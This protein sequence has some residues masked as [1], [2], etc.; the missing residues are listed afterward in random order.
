MFGTRVFTV[1]WHRPQA[2][3]WHSPQQLFFSI[4]TC[5]ILSRWYGYTSLIPSDTQAGI[6]RNGHAQSIACSS[7]LLG[8]TSHSMSSVSAPSQCFENRQVSQEQ[9]STQFALR[10]SVSESHG[11]LDQQEGAASA[12]GAGATS[13]GAPSFRHSLQVTFFALVQ[14]I[15]IQKLKHTPPFCL[16]W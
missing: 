16:F 4:D 12:R 13:P 14:A 11:E 6:Y 3:R 9:S 2:L 10:R 1:R 8:A 15:L 5:T 7:R